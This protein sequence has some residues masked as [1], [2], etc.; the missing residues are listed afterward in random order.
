MNTEEALEQRF[1]TRLLDVLIRAAL[2]LVLALLCYQVFAPFLPLMVW[3][4]ILAVT[5][6]PLHRALAGKLG[7]RRG[8]AASLIT[9]LGIALIVAPASVLLGSVG[10]SVHR[11]VNG[12][13]ENSLEVPPPPESVAGW[14]VV[15]K[16]VHSLWERAH[17]D[18]PALIKSMQPKIGDLAKA[19]LSMVANIG[20]GILK[21]I[22]AFI[23]AG[24]V[25][26]FGEAGARACRGPGR[27]RART[28]R[29]RCAGRSH[30]R[31]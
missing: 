9:L 14:P 3:A 21:F 25:M 12:V 22:V 7:G 20:G 18:L 11:L 6:Y 24:I 19:A 26:A 15:G 23:V 8:W 16:K 13:Q 17:T 5:L 10:D 29:P 31:P 1:A 28:R 27:R 2:I 4:I 30:R